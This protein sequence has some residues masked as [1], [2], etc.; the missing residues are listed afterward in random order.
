MS[1]TNHATA[2]SNMIRIARLQE[3]LV[4]A[5]AALTRAGIALKEVQNQLKEFLRIRQCTS[6][7]AAMM[8]ASACHPACLCGL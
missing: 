2:E 8:Q 1:D 3:R 7:C 4:E 5:E 6:S